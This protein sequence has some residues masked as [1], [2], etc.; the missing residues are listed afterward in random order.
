MAIK[1]SAGNEMKTHGITKNDGA[2]AQAGE[3]YAAIAMAMHEFH[4]NAHDVENTVITIN[5]V[6]RRYSPW[7]SKIYTLRETPRRK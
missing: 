4:D 2:N 3:I 7:S 1:I 6:K 5:R